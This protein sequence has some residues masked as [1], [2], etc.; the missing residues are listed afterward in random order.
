MSQV[1]A[2]APPSV[3]RLDAASEARL[4]WLRFQRHRL[5]MIG[6]VITVALALLAVFAETVS[7]FDP[8]KSNGRFAFAPPQPIHWID[9]D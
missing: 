8:G 2:A 3:S 9:Q 4:F 5:A 7:P 1:L 6:L